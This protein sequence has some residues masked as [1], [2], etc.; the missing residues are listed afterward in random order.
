MHG[1]SVQDF[2]AYLSDMW[3]MTLRVM[4]DIKESVRKAGVMCARSLTAMTMRAIEPSSPE[5]RSRETLELVIPFLLEQGVVSSSEEAKALSLDTLVKICKQASP[6]PL[7]PFVVQIA[8]WL[9]EALSGLE[10]QVLNYLSFHVGKYELSPEQLDKS[11]LAATRSSPSMEAIEACLDRF[12]DAC[13]EAFSPKLQALLRKGIGLPTKAGSARVVALLCFKSPALF[14]PHAPA[15]L[16]ALSGTIV[17]KN[18]AVRSSMITAL[19]Q[20]TALV[21]AE[22][23]GKLVKHLRKIYME[24]ADS[25]LHGVAGQ[26]IYEISKHAGPVLR[27]CLSDVIPLLFVARFDAD[28]AAA[29]AWTN[30]W[31]ELNLESKGTLRLYRQEIVALMADCLASTS[32]PVRQQGALAVAAF[33]EKAA[34]DT[35]VA[36][37][38]PISRMLLDGL[39]GRVWQGKD[40]LPR[41]V[42]A[43]LSKAQKAAEEDPALS[44]AVAALPVAEIS[45]ALY[46]EAGK[47]DL[48]YRRAVL[49]SLIVLH[50]QVPCANYAAVADVIHDVLAPME[51]DA[52]AAPAKR[53]DDEAD[54]EPKTGPLTYLCA[55][56]ALRLSAAAVA[57]ADPPVDPAEALAVHTRLVKFA[58]D[59]TWAVR[60]GAYG[61]LET[62]FKRL[63]SL[64]ALQ[65]AHADFVLAAASL[66]LR[67]ERY[68]SVKAAHIKALAALAS[69]DDAAV[70][71]QQ[72]GT[73][74]ADVVSGFLKDGSPAEVADSAS[75][76]LAVLRGRK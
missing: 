11:R 33:T 75:A 20:T 4:D 31:E 54:D 6:A 51:V 34:A 73:A 12:D 74:L 45:E 57:A 8:S 13:M 39:A 76:L 68:S 49:E 21:D 67:D 62:L 42:V 17:D 43:L 35:L 19:A 5:A 70:I 52:K 44:A 64:E 24:N 10:P 60:Q 2:K 40:A 69:R 15:I 38:E 18:A 65:Q 47:R 53:D 14:K 3:F 28:T 30:A 56:A 55:A 61:G 58:G 16:K 23:C 72:H 46:R 41:A 9:L 29:A 26:C 36:A 50:E 66:T 7:R 1:R 59:P 32:W 63:P 71:L 37:A 48:T 25:D 22:T 27:E